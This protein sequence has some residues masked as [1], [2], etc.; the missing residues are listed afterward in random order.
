MA[1]G[2]W[3]GVPREKKAPAEPMAGQKKGLGTEMVSPP[4]PLDLRCPIT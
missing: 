4:R 3:V 1:G 2:K